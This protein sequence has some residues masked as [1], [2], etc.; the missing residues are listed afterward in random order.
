MKKLILNFCLIVLISLINGCSLDNF[1]LPSSTPN[2]NESLPIIEAKSIKSISDISSVALEW[3]NITDSSE[4]YGY[5]IYRSNLKED[6]HKLKRI[7]T[8]ES[9]Y[10]SHYLDK[11]LEPNTKYLYAISTIGAKHT[12]SLASNSI[13]VQT[14]PRL[15][16]V[17][18]IT[19]VSELP[20]QVKILW[21]PHPDKRV[22]K[23]IIERKVQ[24]DS[25]FRKI[26]SIKQ[27]L[28]VEYLDTNLMDN[29]KYSYRIKVLTFD[30][31]KS[32]PSEITSATTKALPT[33]VT[34]IQ[35][36]TNLPRMIKLTW[37]H[38]QD[39]KDI[40][41]YKIYASK[42]R[43]GS[44]ELVGTV[45]ISSETV[46]NHSIEHDGVQRFYK[47]TTIDKDHLES[48]KKVAPI[49]GQTLRA[50]NPPI[51]TLAMIKDNIIILNWKAGDTR[52]VSYN[53]YKTTKKNF[54]LQS[55]ESIL[56][57]KNERFEDKD[58][59]RGVTYKYKIEAVDQYGLVS[60]KT[61]TVTLTIPELVDIKNASSVN[62]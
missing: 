41:S 58:T 18:F 6:K 17:S 51:I 38:P 5:H 46:F 52:T 8:L 60:K 7:A 29:T 57:I 23:Y 13:I 24:G 42:E 10:T 16:S 4:V 27:R 36:T 39:I 9:K 45:P 20:R 54:I 28:Q 62:D 37:K 44:F 11:N 15:K 35:A 53:I 19:S 30:G 33:N 43:E 59:T 56:D 3:K 12:E 48:T 47:I 55:T 40:V 22:E 32:L 49:V 2:I 25:K 61:H 26:A 21:R 34:N 31:I 50:P 1:D 14:K